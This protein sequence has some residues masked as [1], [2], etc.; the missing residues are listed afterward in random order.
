VIEH[1]IEGKADFD[2]IKK[3]IGY[4]ENKIGY[5]YRIINV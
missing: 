2:A 3:L 4:L 5:V 1:L